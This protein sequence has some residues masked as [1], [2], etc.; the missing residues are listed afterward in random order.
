VLF[1][2]EHIQVGVKME[3]KANLARLGMFYGNKTTMP[4]VSCHFPV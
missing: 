3:V 4:F 1:E 2:T